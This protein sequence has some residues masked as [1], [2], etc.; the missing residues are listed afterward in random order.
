MNVAEIARKEGHGVTMAGAQTRTI[1]S[2]SRRWT[3]F[4]IGFPGRTI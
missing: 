1:T 3:R 2:R 4:K